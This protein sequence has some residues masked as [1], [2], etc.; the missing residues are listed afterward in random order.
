MSEPNTVEVE[1]MSDPEAGA[2]W[3]ELPKTF[4]IRRRL[5][6]SVEQ[7]AERYCIPADIVRAWEAGQAKPDAVAEAYLRAIATSP[8]AVADAVRV[9]AAAE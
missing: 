6:L 8:D 4:G 9:R 2:I 1:A 7:F 3:C 5:K